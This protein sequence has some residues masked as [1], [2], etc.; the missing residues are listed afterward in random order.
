[1]ETAIKSTFLELVIDEKIKPFHVDDRVRNNVIRSLSQS[2]IEEI[3][4]KYGLVKPKFYVGND[5]ERYN[6]QSAVISFYMEHED[7][8][9]QDFPILE[10]LPV[11]NF[12]F[13]DKERIV[14]N[15]IPDGI[16]RH[17]NYLSYLELCWDNHYPIVIRPDFIYHIVLCEIAGH[18]KENAEKF[19]NLF[20]SSSEKKKLLVYSFDPYILPLHSMVD[21]LV[22]NIPS[23]I[24]SLLPEFSTTTESSRFALAAAFCDAMSPYYSY[25]MMLCG[26]PKARVEGTVDDWKKVLSSLHSVVDM[27]ELQDYYCKVEK[28]IQNVIDAIVS[29]DG[30]HLQNMFSLVRCGSGGQVKVDGW[31]TDLF[32]QY[33]RVGYVENFSSC[34][35]SVEYKNL[36]NQKDYVMKSGLL[37]S[38]FEGEYLVPDFTFI[39]YEK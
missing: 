26:I 12:P 16:I 33:P 7:Q 25:M 20:T 34:V 22:K 31:I 39:V 32:M 15:N 28:A 17:P 4:S 30:R 38:T 21:E 9:E 13:K 35:S 10:N 5:A 1:M 11:T 19:R 18:I 36:S 29:E 37:R 27:L 24:T 8:F 23:D 6:G 3:I 2:K 14:V